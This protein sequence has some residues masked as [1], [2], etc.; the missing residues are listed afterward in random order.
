M[1]AGLWLFGANDSYFPGI[2]VVTQAPMGAF[3]SI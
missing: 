2:T 3:Q 1:Y